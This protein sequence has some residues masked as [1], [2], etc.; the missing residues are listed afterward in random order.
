M[1]DVAYDP[2]GSRAAGLSYGQRLSQMGLD[3][4]AGG[5]LAGGNYQAAAQ[6]L[7]QGGD[8]AGGQAVQAAQ[9][10]NETARRTRVTADQARLA[11]FTLQAARTL[12]GVP[13]EQRAQAFSQLAPT[14]K[15]LGQT[16]EDIAAFGAQLSQNPTLI[17]QAEQWAGDTLLKWELRAGDNGDTV[18]V[19]LNERTGDTQSRLAYAAPQAPQVTALGIITPPA[20]ALPVGQSQAVQAGTSTA[21][22]LPQSNVSGP[23]PVAP[24]T[25]SQISNAPLW[26]RQIQQESGGRQFDQSG[27]VLTSPAGAFGVAQL[28]PGTAQ[29]LAR[30]M[31]VS[32]EQLRA[33]PALNEAAGRMYQ[34]QQ[35]AKYGGNEALALAAYNAGPGRVDEWIQRFGDPRTGE[36]TTEEF[37]SR[38]PFAETKQ[39]VENITQGQYGQGDNEGSSG[40][41]SG[42]LE[43]LGNGYTLQRVQTPADARAARAETRA[44]AAERRAQE[45]FERSQRTEQRTE[46]RLQD[47]QQRGDRTAQS[48]L[49]REFNS[50]PEVKEFREVDN[51]YRTIQNF[52]QRPSAAG[53]ISMIFAFMKVLDPTSTV[54]EGEFATASN[55]GG[56]PDSIRNLANRAVNGQRLQPNQRQDFLR[57]AGAIRQSREQRYN[58]VLGEY[59]FEAEQQ[60]FDPSRIIGGRGEQQSTSPRTNAPGLRFNITPEQLQTRQSIVG[61]GQRGQ[62][63]LGSAQNPYYLNPSDARGSYANLPSGAQYVSPDGQIR[64]KR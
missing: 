54:R 37:V 11:G 35:L 36:I 14:L 49:R 5:Q 23:T 42:G 17:D 39:Y 56:V 29:D 64:T 60:G 31:G 19:G 58:E 46:Q 47:T 21:S 22:A 25:G 30:Q 62:G 50:R 40:Q 57:Q 59:R 24:V 8:L 28:M 53:D 12:K 33:D 51:S 1:S 6:T 3:R 43:Q 20:R 61:Q 26:D 41:Q 4:R 34:D 16:P 55:A 15:L 27:A 52:V 32:V 18:A 48:A 38:I 45:G 10:A 44:E 7:F 63:R 9:T 2:F 13:P